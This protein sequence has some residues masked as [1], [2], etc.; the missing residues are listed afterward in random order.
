[1][2]CLFAGAVGMSAKSKLMHSSKQRIQKA[3]LATVPPKS[4]QVF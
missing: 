1:M 2:A 4:D 3:R